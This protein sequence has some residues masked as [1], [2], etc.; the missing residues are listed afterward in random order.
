MARDKKKRGKTAGSFANTF[1]KLK[2]SNRKATKEEGKIQ[3]AFALLEGHH[4]GSGNDNGPASTTNVPIPAKKEP[5][6][7]AD[8]RRAGP[9]RIAT[10]TEEV[11]H[12]D[13]N[14]WRSFKTR[15][16]AGPQ[17]EPLTAHPPVTAN[18][19]SAPW[20][21]TT[22]WRERDPKAQKAR[23]EAART[24]GKTH[25]TFKSRRSRMT[26]KAG[27]RTIGGVLF[28][29][30]IP[31]AVTWHWDE[32]PYNQIGKPTG[33]YRIFK[34]ADGTQW[35]QKGRYWV[36]VEVVD[37]EKVYEVPIY[38]NND[39]GL[40]SVKPKFWKDYFSL[41]PQHIDPKDF[42]NQSPENEVLEMIWMELGDD[43]LERK[44]VRTTMVVHWSEIRERSIDIQ[45]LRLVGKMAPKSTEI[46][47]ARAFN[48]D[49]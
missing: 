46:L 1:S 30:Q 10:I 6:L 3:N 33:R 26:Y 39:T 48:D 21:T 37:D 16:Q 25:N 23:A 34:K 35:M 31:G 14:S 19:S 27:P 32:R 24:I 20:L 29:D 8:G 15:D 17:K 18:G 40:R 13:A 45:E 38:S 9:S 36:I 7:D 11:N 49:Q 44:L 12:A 4:N 41:C 28:A 2:L 43:E 42:H 5:T 22:N 47:L